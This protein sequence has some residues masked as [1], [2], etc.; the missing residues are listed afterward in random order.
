MKRRKRVFLAGLLSSA[1]L[2]WHDF[3]ERYID[4]TLE[5]PCGYSS[6]AKVFSYFGEDVNIGEL[7]E[8]NVKNSKRENF[9]REV[10]SGIYKRLD[11]IIFPSEIE[12]MC[13]MHGY[14]VH[15][16][17]DNVA[18]RVRKM[19]EEGRAGIVWL[20]HPSLLKHHWEA[21]PLTVKNNVKALL[22]DEFQGHYMLKVFEIQKDLVRR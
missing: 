9:Y 8:E 20:V 2:A 13:L 21:V 19:E 6:V 4:N 3:N 15:R 14:S 1:I 12:K 11:R 10:L 17:S 18:E 5:Y 22:Q 7:V 16:Y